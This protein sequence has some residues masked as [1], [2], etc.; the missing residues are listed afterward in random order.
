MHV[1]TLTLKG[2]TSQN[3]QRHPNNSSAVADEL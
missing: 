3:G 2:P 1:H